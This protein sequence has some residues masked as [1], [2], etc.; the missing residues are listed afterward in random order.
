MRRWLSSNPWVVPLVFAVLIGVVGYSANEAL[1]RTMKHQLAEDLSTILAADRAAIDLWVEAQREALEVAAADDELRAAVRE[2]VHLARTAD[3]PVAVLVDAPAGERVRV[4]MA[5]LMARA[6]NVAFGVFDP[7]GLYIAGTGAI[8]SRPSGQEAR[9]ARVLRGETIVTPPLSWDATRG[10]ALSILVATPVLDGRERPIAVLGVT[11]DAHEEFLP[12]LELARPAESGETYAFNA[13]GLMLSASRFDAQLREL[14]LLPDDPSV[15]S[16]LTIEIRDPGGDMTQGFRPELPVKSRPLTRMAGDA[17]AGNAGVDVD[18]YN[19]YRGVPVVGAWAWLPDLE[20]GITTE[21]DVA[22]AFAGLAAVRLRMFAVFGLLVIAGCAMLLYGI[23]LQRMQSRVDEARQLGRYSVLR[24][25]GRG[26]MGTVFAARHALLRRPTAIKVLEADAS[27]GEAIARFERE[28]QV[29]SQLTHPNTIDIYDFGRAPD[30]T[31]YYAMELVVGY[32]LDGVV[33]QGG[34][35]PEGRVVHVMSQVCG[36]I[37]EAHRAGMIH[38]DLKP[39]NVML[40]VQ[41][42]LYDFVKVLDFGLVRQIDQSRDAALTDVTSLSGTPLYMPPEMIQS[43]DTVD[44]R[45]DIYQL[46]AIAYFLLTGRNVFSGDSPYD[47]LAKHAAATPTSPSEALGRPVSP[48]LERLILNCLAKDPGDR[49]EDGGALLEAFER[50]QVDGVWA[51]SDARKWWE[52]R[53]LESFEDL[54]MSGTHPSGYS[55]DMD[56]RIAAARK[57]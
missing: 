44:Q 50:C 25:I 56:A 1:E 35:L 47:V 19:D 14:G 27:G 46:G 57:G 15:E 4:H 31:F 28:V 6:G 20:M 12:L 11:V 40:C 45:A 22:E 32:T 5:P 54:G 2:L 55:I 53:E 7:S 42:G 39:S 48:D 16:A 21:V 49:F 38:R 41:G 34:P 18:G 3:D 51:Q 17:V 30:G 37:A 24:K 23:V 33:T 36:S 52:G 10:G 9:Q 29:A 26:G 8:G 13:D 43:P